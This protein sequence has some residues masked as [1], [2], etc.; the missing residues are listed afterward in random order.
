[1]KAVAAVDAEK[2]TMFVRIHL[3]LLLTLDFVLKHF[4]FCE[5]FI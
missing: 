4:I 3:L 5:G 2:Q 1:M